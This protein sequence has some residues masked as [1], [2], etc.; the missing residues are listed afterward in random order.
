[1]TNRVLVREFNGVPVETSLKLELR[2]LD[3][4]NPGA[5]AAIEV[6]QE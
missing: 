6:I 1:M 2:H 5:I 4:E 3:A